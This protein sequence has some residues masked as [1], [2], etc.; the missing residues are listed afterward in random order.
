[1]PT[2]VYVNDQGTAIER[3]GSMADCMPA[4]IEENGSVYRRVFQA[5]PVIYR[6]MGFYSTDNAHSIERWR[7]E[8][9][10]GE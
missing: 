5:S 9:L 8:N 3:K 7:R 4:E 2:Y 6:A 1:M 10:Q